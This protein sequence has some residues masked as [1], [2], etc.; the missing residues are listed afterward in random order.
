MATGR[1][2]G[3]CPPRTGLT[4][5]RIFPDGQVQ[6]HPFE[7]VCPFENKIR[8]I[9]MNGAREKIHVNLRAQPGKKTRK[10]AKESWQGA[11]ALALL[12]ENSTVG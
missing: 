7:P 6:I 3:L 11:A 5:Y 9:P 12:A 4:D 10:I 8:F 1:P 2:V